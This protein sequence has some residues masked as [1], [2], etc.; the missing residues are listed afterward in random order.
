MSPRTFQIGSEAREPQTLLLFLADTPI[1]AVVEAF[2]DYHD[3]FADWLAKSYKGE[4]PS[5]EDERGAIGVMITG[6]GSSS[7]FLKVVSFPIASA[8]ICRETIT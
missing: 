4:Y 6:S 3:I 5:E 8:R 2:G 1:P 7:D